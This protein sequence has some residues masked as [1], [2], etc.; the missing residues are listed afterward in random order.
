LTTYYILTFLTRTWWYIS[1][2]SFF[3]KNI[4]NHYLDKFTKLSN[5]KTE[6]IWTGKLISIIWTGMDAWT[7]LLNKTIENVLKVLFTVI[8]TIYMIWVVNIWA[9]FVFIILYILVH[10]VWEYFNRKSLIYRRKRQDIWNNYTWSLV[11]LL[12]SKFEILQ[13]WQIN[14]ELKSINTLN[15]G[16]LKESIN[17]ATPIH[18]FFYIPSI[19]INTVK[20]LMFIFLGYQVILWNAT[21][22][23]FVALFWIL[24]VMNR[25]TINSMIFYSD[26]TNNFTKIENMW[27]FFDNTSKIKWYDK[28]YDFEY[29]K[30]NIEIK[31]LTYW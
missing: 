17:M 14:R 31:R 19:F 15:D 30:G 23:L 5:N 13:T 11:K 8:F 22:S 4:N 18:W 10:I 16:M 6:M 12:M 1:C 2:I 20:I 27:N 3:R 26:F 25:V 7:I 24:T 9:S 28:W 21:F 29:K